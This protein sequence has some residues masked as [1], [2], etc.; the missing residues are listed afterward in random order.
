M[1]LQLKGKTAL[2]AGASSVGCG[3]AIAKMLAREG[4]VKTTGATSA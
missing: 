4:H 1:D 2:V 3:S